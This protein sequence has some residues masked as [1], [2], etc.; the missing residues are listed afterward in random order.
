MRARICQDDSLTGDAASVDKSTPENLANLEKIGNDLLNKTV[1]RVNV[2][3]GQYEAVEG[4]ET[5]KVALTR[6]AK[7]LSDE[8]RRRK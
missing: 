7:M 4:D 3:T 5:N 8:L 6:F 1:S 2:E